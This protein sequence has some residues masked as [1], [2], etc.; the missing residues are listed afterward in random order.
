MQTVAEH[1]KTYEYQR[2]SV[3]TVAFICCRWKSST[4][5]I[6]ITSWIS[7]GPSPLFCLQLISPPLNQYSQ[8]HGLPTLE[9]F[10]NQ[11][12]L[13]SIPYPSHP[14]H[15]NPEPFLQLPGKGTA[16]VTLIVPSYANLFTSFVKQNVLHYD[17]EQPSL[18]L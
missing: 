5:R 12:P 10:L 2:I 1:R 7:S 3:R 4:S 9:H 8:P 13:H 11:S 14:V 6:L 17:F 18:G 15:P 16:M